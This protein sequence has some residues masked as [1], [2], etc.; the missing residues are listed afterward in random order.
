M[1]IVSV[2]NDGN[3]LSAPPSSS[4]LQ[5]EILQKEEAENNLAA[6]R[7]DVD[8]ATLARLDLERRIETLQEEIAFLKKIHEEVP[9]PSSSSSS[10]VSL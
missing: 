2:I 5:D 10:S 3:S 7:A 4:R 8:A 1:F 9:P 6:F